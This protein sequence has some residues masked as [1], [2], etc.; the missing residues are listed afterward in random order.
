[1]LRLTPDIIFDSDR[2]GYNLA[3]KSVRGGME[4]KSAINPLR[5]LIELNAIFKKS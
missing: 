2:L 4:T 1:M 5:A 3:R